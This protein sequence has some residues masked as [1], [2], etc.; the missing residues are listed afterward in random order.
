M[1]NKITITIKK[2]EMDLLPEKAIFWKE[3]KILILADFHLGKAS[4]F[5]KSG[6]PIPEGD[7]QDDL[8]RLAHLLEVNKAQRC[9]IVGDLFHHHRGMTEHTITLFDAW[10]KT[11][12]CPLDLVLG[13]HD[14]GIKNLQQTHWP[15]GLHQR[16][17]ITPFAFEH[18]P[19]EIEDHFTL[20]GH[21]HPQTLLK[22]RTKLLRLP[23]FIVGKHN[24]ILP[25]FSSFAGGYLLKRTEQEE[26][27][28]IVGQDVIKM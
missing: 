25:A 27:F 13:N 19:C 14:R 6:I 3:Q 1:G 21:L 16:L 7:M 2:Q 10:L 17:L 24:A 22:V 18:I 9:I 5:R 20:S 12:P 28:A 11:L 15:I 26:V 8:Q 23:C 4:T